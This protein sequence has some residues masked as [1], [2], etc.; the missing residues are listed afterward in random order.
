MDLR[1]AREAAGLTRRE[2]AAL[3]GVDRRDLQRFEQGRKRPNAGYVRWL[4][5]VYAGAHSGDRP[6]GATNWRGCG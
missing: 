5:R 4:L 2:A 1:A 3:A 6:R